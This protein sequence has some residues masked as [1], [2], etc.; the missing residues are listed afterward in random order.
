MIDDKISIK[1]TRE[2]LEIKN[3]KVNVDN[4]NMVRSTG[5]P[6]IQRR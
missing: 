5:L 2:D 4:M 3:K 6:K 1:V